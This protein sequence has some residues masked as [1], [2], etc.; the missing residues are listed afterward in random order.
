MSLVPTRLLVLQRLCAL[1]EPVTY[2]YSGQTYSLEGAVFRGRQ[3]IGEE[4]KPLPVISI[5]EAARP[6]V[7]VY[8][9]EEAQ[10]MTDRWMLLI[11]GMCSNDLLNPTE[12][13]YH[14]SAAVL[15]QLSRVIAI[16]QKTGNPKYPED[17]HLGN[18]I[19]GCEISPPVVRPPD[20]KASAVAFFFLPIRVGIATEFAEPYTSVP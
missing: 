9:S 13:G 10:R 11:T 20:D 4:S 18:L 2:E 19:T 5:L 6:D 8:A 7:A 1:L 15:K 3:L 16:N 12:P 14:F 17:F